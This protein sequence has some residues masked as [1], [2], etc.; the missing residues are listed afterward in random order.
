MGVPGAVMGVLYAHSTA[1]INK[2]INRY[3]YKSGVGY[4]YLF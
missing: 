4:I 2:G 1:L 3:I